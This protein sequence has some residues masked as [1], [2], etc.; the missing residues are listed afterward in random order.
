MG[1][2]R[3]NENLLMRWVAAVTTMLTVGVGMLTSAA[4]PTTPPGWP[5]FG[6]NPA[7]TGVSTSETTIGPSNVGSLIAAFSTALPATA[8]GPVTFLPGVGTAQGTQDLIFATTRNGWITAVDAHTGAAVWSDQNG[9]G[10]CTIN[11]GSNACYTT[12]SPAVDPN[13]LY[14]YSYG[15]DG[16]VHKY[17]TGSGA[18]TTGGGWPQLATT[19]PFDEKGSSALAIASVAGTTYLYVANG[20]YPGDAGDYQGHLTVVNLATGSQNVF[21]TLCSNRA[22]HFTSTPATDC[23]QHQSAVW[24]RGGVTYD[25]ATGKI[26]FAT[27]N[28]QFDGVTSWGDSVLALNPDGTGLNGAPTS[29]FTP[30]DQSGLN[31]ADADLGSTAPALVP[32]PTGSTI[33]HLAV[34]GGKDAKL[35][36]LN[37]DNLSGQGGSGHLGGELQTISLPQGGEILTQPA[38]WL[39]PADGRSWVFVSTNNGISGLNVVSTAGTPTLVPSWTVKT[40]G[41]SPIIANGVM[42][43]L[44]GAGLRALDPGTG[45]QLWAESTGSV[46]VHWQSPIIAAGCLYYPDGN[47]NLRAF[48]LPASPAPA[49]SSHLPVFSSWRLPSYSPFWG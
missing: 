32:A 33:A 44:T 15:L 14:V 6:N 9:P 43:Y 19:K 36:L 16:F 45:R 34:Q 42:Y 5:E 40:G 8:D 24:A 1:H 17:A 22:I 29:S 39:N 30:S 10:S 2:A 26:Y 3:F 46:N 13:G 48:K 20:G 23:D 11:N 25:A 35:R 21:N 12:S 18:E 27:G 28:A 47:G 38:T 41:T 49:K 37:L 4:G 31:S 7:H